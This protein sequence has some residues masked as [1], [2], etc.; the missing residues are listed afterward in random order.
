M[1]GLSGHVLVAVGGGGGGSK[2]CVAWIKVW[3]GFLILIYLSINQAI[4][5]SDAIP[6]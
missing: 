1:V 2:E 5:L 3:V 4:K 6:Y